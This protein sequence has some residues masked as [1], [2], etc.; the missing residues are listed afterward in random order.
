MSGTKKVRRNYKPPQIGPKNIA[1]YWAA[2]IIIQKSG[3]LKMQIQARNQNE[4]RNLAGAKKVRRN[5]K[6][7][8]IGP[9]EYISLQ[10]RAKR[11]TEEWAFKDANPDEKSKWDAYRGGGEEGA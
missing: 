8:K 4:M 5:D 6:P 7:P 11:N 1:P 3:H 9:G 10:S 2:Q